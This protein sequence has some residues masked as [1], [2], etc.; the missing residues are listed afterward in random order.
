MEG[1]SVVTSDDH[2]LG[3]VVAE[4]DGFVVVESGH[5]FKARHAIPTEFLHEHDE[6]V[7]ATVGKDVVLDSPKVE[8]DTFDPYEVKMHYGL[9]EANVVADPDPSLTAPR[10]P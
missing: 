8:G 2:K 4:P 7:R 10:E 1:R 3:T 5:M 6:V 9:I